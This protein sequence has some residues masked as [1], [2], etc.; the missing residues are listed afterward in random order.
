MPGCHRRR[1]CRTSNANS[2]ARNGDVRLVVPQVTSPRGE[3]VAFE[4]AARRHLTRAGS[5]G[6]AAP[7]WEQ[8]QL[9]SAGQ[10]T[11]PQSVRGCRVALQVRSAPLPPSGP[12]PPA[13]RSRPA[14]RR[15]PPSRRAAMMG[16][17][18]L[19]SC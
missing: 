5:A 16:G 18:V 17:G 12:P 10:V 8:L 4:R 9:L 1:A 2:P 7:A 11:G 14:G 6:V 3:R 13:P 19:Q 15:P